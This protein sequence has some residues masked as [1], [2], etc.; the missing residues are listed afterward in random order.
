MSFNSSLP[1]R[2][3]QASDCDIVLLKLSSIKSG[4]FRYVVEGI[5]EVD[6]GNFSKIVGDYGNE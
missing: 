3:D 2:W 1:S 5:V 4:S 6:F